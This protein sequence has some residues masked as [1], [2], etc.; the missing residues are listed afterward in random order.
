VFKFGT[1]RGR[2]NRFQLNF[3]N[4]R[5]V[6]VVDGRVAFVGGLNVGDEYMG[7]SKRFGHWR[8][9]HVRLEGPIVQCVQVVFTSDWYWAARELPSV[10]WTPTPTARAPQ[11]MLALPTGP[12]D[13]HDRCTF[14]FLQAI[15][16]AKKRV[17][18]ASPYFVPDP[19]V[20]QALRLAALRGVD[21]RV[22]LPEK[23]DHKLVYLASFSFLH[24]AETAGVQIFRYDDGFLHQKV[25]L[26]DDEAASVGTVNLDNR[27]LH[28]NFEITILVVDRK[29]A[30]S[31]A[32]MLERDFTKCRSVTAADYWNRGR[33]FRAAVRGARLLEP[34]L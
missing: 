9:T 34:I 25:L 22:M 20:F 23:P 2:W 27:S 6:V 13:E 29:F 16:A 14:F 32:A 3:R 31:V 30:S 11:T 12:T 21:V 10:E 33:L 7:R 18:I 15:T 19:P 8:D 26:V 1:Q 4:H 24:D 28:L 5:K 17:W